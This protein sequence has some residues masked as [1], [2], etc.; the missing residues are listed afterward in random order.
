MKKIILMAFLACFSCG[1]IIF[2]SDGS[3]TNIIG[4]TTFHSNGDTNTKIGDTYFHSDGS[5]STIME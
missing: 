3:T 4:D 2:H 1:E 5:Y